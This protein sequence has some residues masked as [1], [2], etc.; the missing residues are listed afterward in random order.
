[1]ERLVLTNGAPGQRLFT[2]E[3]AE[4]FTQKL[5]GLIGRR[6]LD[7][8]E[9]LYFPGTNSLHMLFMRFAIDA[10]FLGPP[11]PDGRS[12]IVAVRDRLRPW[13]GVVWWVRG[14]RGRGGVIELAAGAASA[15]GLRKGDLVR[16]ER[17][18]P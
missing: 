2:L 4:S 6:S 3:V 11:G 1:M 14:V 10:V 5:R 12:E 13:L 17:L 16:M 9:G 15:A 18:A 8:G 7:P